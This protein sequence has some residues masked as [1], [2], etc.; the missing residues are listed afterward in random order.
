MPNTRALFL[1]ACLLLATAAQAQEDVPPATPAVSDA[2]YKGIVGKVLDSVPMD[3]DERV[4][5]QRTS[6]VVSGTLTGRS[7]TVWS[8]L[9]H[10]ILW[11]AGIAWG[12]ISASNIR[13]EQ[14]VAKPVTTPLVVSPE[15]LGITH[16]QVAALAAPPA[17]EAGDE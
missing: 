8:G 10:P 2:F 17:A 9:T 14:P 13:A 16:T 7:L 11:V 6:A 3:P 5:L 12:L 4:A 15:L 1:T